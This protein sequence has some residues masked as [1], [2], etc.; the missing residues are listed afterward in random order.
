MTIRLPC[1]EVLLIIYFKW[2]H[3]YLCTIFT[4]IYACASGVGKLSG[5]LRPWHLYTVQDADLCAV[6]ELKRPEKERESNP[7]L[8]ADAV[9]FIAAPCLYFVRLHSSYYIVA[10]GGPGSAKNKKKQTGQPPTQQSTTHTHPNPQDFHA[11]AS[12][13]VYIRYILLY[14]RERINIINVISPRDER[15]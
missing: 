10:R 5:R 2:K 4:C 9:G 6:I 14:D 11:R 3:L 7:F 8:N 1:A 15:L 13:D 12:S